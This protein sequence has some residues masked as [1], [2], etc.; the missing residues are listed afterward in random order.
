[1]DLLEKIWIIK[2]FDILLHTLLG[3]S[4]PMLLSILFNLTLVLLAK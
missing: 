1:M 4:M 3:E 2:F